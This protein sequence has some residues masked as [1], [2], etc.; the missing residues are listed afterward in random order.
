[1]KPLR[2]SH[3]HPWLVMPVMLLALTAAASAR[4]QAPPTAIPPAPAPPVAEPAPAAPTPAPPAAEPA[5]AA[6][7]PAGAEAPSPAQFPDIF[8]VRTWAPPPPP[9]QAEE[10]A[11]AP[12]APPLPFTF[13]GRITEK[14]QVAAF[15]LTMG[16]RVLTVRVGDSIDHTYRLEKYQKGQ[17][18][19]RYRPMNVR[20]VLEI[21]GTS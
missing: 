9:P 2:A 16:S 5:P 4:G 19:F 6:A 11:P 15:L 18:I 12:E 1:M 14:G 13:L 17:L 3:R 10:G 8:A 7:P 21:G 20:Q